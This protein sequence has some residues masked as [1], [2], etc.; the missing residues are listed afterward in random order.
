MKKIRSVSNIKDPYVKRILSYTIGKDAFTVYS[1][2]PKKLQRLTKRLSAPQLRKSVVKGKWSITQIIN[3]LCD[4]ELVM[5]FRYR[6]AIA[7]TG[8]RLQAFDESEWAKR[9]R[10]ESSDSERKLELFVKMRKD[11]IALLR[12]LRPSEWKLYGMHEERGKETIERMVQMMAGHDINHLRQV[13]NIRKALLHR[14][15]FL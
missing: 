7:Q 13:K 11:H 4:S 15:R 1:Q 10:Y 8:S 9:L 12:N 2:T 6:M 5:G 14:R 3:H